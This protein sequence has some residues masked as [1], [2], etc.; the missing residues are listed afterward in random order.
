MQECVNFICQWE[1]EPEG[2]PLRIN[3]L[4]HSSA[5]RYGKIFH[6][7]KASEISHAD[8]C[9]KSYISKPAI[10]KPPVN[11]ASCTRGGQ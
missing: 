11:L 4:L 5:G 6:E 9:N 7:P 1:N 3:H 8:S 2:V 10:T